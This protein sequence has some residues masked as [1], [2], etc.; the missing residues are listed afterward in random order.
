MMYLYMCTCAPICVCVVQAL[1]SLFVSVWWFQWNI[2][3]PHRSFPSVL[4]VTQVKKKLNGRKRLISIDTPSPFCNP[5]P[6]YHHALL[7]WKKT[8]HSL[9]RRGACMLMLKKSIHMCRLTTKVHTAIPSHARCICL[10]R[11]GCRGRGTRGGRKG[12]TQCQGH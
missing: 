11:P 3:P 9:S 8:M 6:H 2:P 12:R 4:S 7:L 1:R 10:V 5:Y